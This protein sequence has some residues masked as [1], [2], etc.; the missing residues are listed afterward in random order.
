MS[1]KLEDDIFDPFTY[2]VIVFLEDEM[3]FFVITL[4]ER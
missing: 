2:F 1:V 4:L 3:L